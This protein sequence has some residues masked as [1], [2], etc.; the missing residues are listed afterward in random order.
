MHSGHCKPYQALT[1]KSC[2]FMKYKGQFQY[3]PEATE[4]HCFVVRIYQS[5]SGKWFS[6]VAKDA[7]RIATLGPFE[8]KTEAITHT[9]IYDDERKEP[10]VHGSKT[11]HQDSPDNGRRDGGKPD[12][13]RDGDSPVCESG[14]KG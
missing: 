8:T 4:H 5:K 2:V 7:I 12:R 9:G 3:E 11:A 1:S 13:Q 10:T 6:T 14:S